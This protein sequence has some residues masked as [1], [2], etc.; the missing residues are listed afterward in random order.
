MEGWSTNDFDDAA[1]YSVELVNAPEGKLQAQENPNIKVMEHIKPLSV[2]KLGDD[3]YIV[4]M[5]QNMVGWM[6]LKVRG[7]QGDK[8][9]LRYAELLK[10][11][12]HLYLDNLRG[13]KVTDTYILKGDEEETWEPKFVFHGFRYVEVSGFPGVPTVDHF[14]GRVVYDEMKTTGTFE[15]SN[16]I[17]NRIYKT[18]AG[19]LKVITVECRQTV[20]NGTNGWDGWA[21]EL[22]EHTAKAIFMTIRNFMQNG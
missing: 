22:P 3:K 14:E 18:H 2:H 19:V 4:D 1:W 20:L 6:T 17:I 9:T 5:G 21:I 12:G 10:E 13:A 15:T 11:D 16:A 8:V 7:K